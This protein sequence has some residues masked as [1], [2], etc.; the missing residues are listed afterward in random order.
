MREELLTYLWK[1]QHSSQKSLIMTFSDNIVVMKPVE[2]NSNA[3]PDFFKVHT[4][5]NKTL[6]VGNVDAYHL[7]I[8]IDF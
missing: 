8:V 1:T 2:E 7:P 6:W 3:G 4:H 5:L